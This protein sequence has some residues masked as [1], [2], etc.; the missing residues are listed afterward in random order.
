MK[1]P[2]TPDRSILYYLTEKYNAIMF[3]PEMSGKCYR[4]NMIYWK[5]LKK[6]SQF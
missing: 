3:V 5:L 2:M 1:S 6:L 4:K